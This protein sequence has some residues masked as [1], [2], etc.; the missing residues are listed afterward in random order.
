MSADFFPVTNGGLALTL[1]NFRDKLPAD[2]KLLGWSDADIQAS[3]GRCDRIISALQAKEKALANYKAQVGTTNKV[4]E[5]ELKALRADIRVIK[6][7]HAY[8]DA[9]GRDL[10]I[11]NV[12]P[13]A[14]IAAG[15]K[16]SI[17]SLEPRSGFVR[18]NWKKGRLDSVNVYLRR[19]GAGETDWRLLGRDTHSPFDDTTP[20]SKPGAPEVREYRVVGVVK[21]AE[22]GT[23]SDIASVTV[24][25]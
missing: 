10:G 8:T 18:I 19:P 4:K 15:D 1:Q 6:S 25:A 12:T 16:A 7:N 2:G 5:V 21:D 9:I 23:A 22:V 13:P 17:A 24:T 3:Q 11:V 14:G 20:L